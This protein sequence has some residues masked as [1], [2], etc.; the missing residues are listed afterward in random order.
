VLLAR[1]V[2]RFI[3]FGWQ[4]T[5]VGSAKNAIN[6]LPLH[7]EQFSI[8]PTYLSLNGLK[9]SG[10]FAIHQKAY[11]LNKSNI[12]LELPIKLHGV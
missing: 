12:K 5:T 8:E 3:L 10:Y 1:F 2:V 7:L 6:N 4:N 9:P 11:Q